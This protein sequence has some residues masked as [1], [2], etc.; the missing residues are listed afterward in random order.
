VDEYDV[1]SGTLA[2]EGRTSVVTVNRYANAGLLDFKRAS[3]GTRLFRRGQE[4]RVREL[5]ARRVAKR[6]RTV[7]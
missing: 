4:Q 2:R 6:D 5:L 3:D 7:G 1:T